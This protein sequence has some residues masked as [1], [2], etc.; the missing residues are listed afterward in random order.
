M[1]MIIAWMGSKRLG[2][3]RVSALWRQALPALTFGCCR[4]PSALSEFRQALLAN[5]TDGEAPLEVVGLRGSRAAR[6]AKRHT[7][8][9]THR[10]E[11]RI[12]NSRC[13]PGCPVV[14]PLLSRCYPAVVPL[15]S[16]CC[17]AVVPLLSRCGPAVV[18]PFVNPFV[19][20]WFILCESV[21][22]SLCASFA[23][24]L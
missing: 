13:C 4:S 20:P 7:S 14:V 17:P 24:P 15:L 3:S 2:V 5:G 18:N 23:H 6:S 16:R 11:K 12:K 22:E 9:K 1:L 21:C 19:S 8:Y 10:V